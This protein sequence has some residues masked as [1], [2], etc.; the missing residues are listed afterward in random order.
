MAWFRYHDAK[1]AED[2]D[3]IIERN[4]QQSLLLCLPS[5]LRNSIYDSTFAGV[6][7]HLYEIVGLDR[8]HVA[9]A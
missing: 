4:A 3:A 6:T 2:Q 7:I 1:T 8:Q 9:C 5:K